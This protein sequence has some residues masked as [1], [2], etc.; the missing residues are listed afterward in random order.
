[1]NNFTKKNVGLI[2]SKIIYPIANIL[3]C[4]IYKLGFTPNQVTFTTLIIRTFA[5]YYMFLKQKPKL[6]F[7]LFVISWFTDA[8]D[9]LI[10]R[11]YNMQSKFGAVFDKIVDYI[12]ILT[13]L[14][15]LLLKYYNNNLVEYSIFY[16]LYLLVCFGIGIKRKTNKDINN[17]Y[18]WKIIL[19]Y[20]EGVCS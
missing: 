9:G 17:G 16:L 6:V 10:A 13:T 18:F 19:T 8:I 3:S 2:D 7:K 1:M 4:P 15:I 11:K 14:V 5:I 12:S 20:F